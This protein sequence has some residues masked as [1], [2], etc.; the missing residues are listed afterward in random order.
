MGSG[1]FPASSTRAAEEEGARVGRLAQ[2]SGGSHVPPCSRPGTLCSA[3]PTC[4]AAP[5]RPAPRLGHDPGAGTALHR[6]ALPAAPKLPQGLL[7]F[8]CTP[9]QTGQSQRAQRLRRT[10]RGQVPA[11]RAAP[12]ATASLCR[13][14]TPENLLLGSCCLFVP[15]KHQR[16]ALRN[17][18]VVKQSTS[19]RHLSGCP[20]A[21]RRCQGRPAGLEEPWVLTSP[22][23]GPSP[24]APWAVPQGC[25]W[26]KGKAGGGIGESLRTARSVG[27]QWERNKGGSA[28]PSQER[29]RPV[30]A[31][32]PV[33]G[34]APALPLP[35]QLSTSSQ[36]SSRAPVPCLLPAVTGRFVCPLL[37]PGKGP[38]A[39]VTTRYA[40]ELYRL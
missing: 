6:T 10:R 2:I 11:P 25:I 30:A 14:R 16:E 17:V 32:S 19:K 34:S 7:H 22:W 33:A 37:S 8:P 26:L 39:A 20:H 21:P 5:R 3:M 28:F 4:R 15:S 18:A 40:A 24:A 1:A 12:S 13:A 29:H 9:P 38:S 36:L 27:Q 23:A 31:D 35:C